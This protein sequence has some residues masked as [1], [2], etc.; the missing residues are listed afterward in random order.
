MRIH[1]VAV[2]SLL[3]SGLLRAD[4]RGCAC[5]AAKPETMQARECGLCREAEK[6]PGDKPFFFL[7][8]IN[9]RKPNRWLVLPRHHGNGP[10]ALADMSQAERTE[11][12]T[13]AIARARELWGDNWGLA[14]NGDESRT[15]CHIHIHIGKLLEGIETRNILVVDGP[16]QIPVPKDGS[17]LWVHPDK[18]KLHVHLGEQITE[19]VLM[20]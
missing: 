7:K 15:Q 3:A 18:G 8:D 10:H 20:R 17:G 5:D 14:I 16:A 12:W 2:L 4:V 9:P 6:Q 19:T 1:L 13:I 11:F